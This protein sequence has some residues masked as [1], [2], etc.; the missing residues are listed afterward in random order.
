M[1]AK[2]AAVPRKPTPEDADQQWVRKLKRD[3]G[4]YAK[5]MRRNIELT[6]V[7]FAVANYIGRLLRWGGKERAKRQAAVPGG[8][9]GRK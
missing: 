9:K 2:K 3:F 5:I 1:A 7:E 6:S 8:R 4:K